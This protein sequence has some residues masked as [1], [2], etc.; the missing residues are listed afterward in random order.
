MPRQ[1]VSVGANASG[2]PKYSPVVPLDTRAVPGVAI[3]LGVAGGAVVFTIE[4]TLDNVFDPLI[5]PVWFPHPDVKLVNATAIQ[6]GNYA[7]PVAAL[8]VNLATGSPGTV[9][10]TVVQPGPQD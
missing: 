5:T 4:Q 8:R 7:Y 1:V 10:L 2:Q 6:Q 9:T 3:Q